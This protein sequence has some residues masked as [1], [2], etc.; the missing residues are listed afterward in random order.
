[1]LSDTHP[2]TIAFLGPL[3]LCAALA[4]AD[5]KESVVEVSD[6]RELLL[7][8]HLFDRIESLSFRLHSPS[9]REKVLDFD[10]PWEGRPSFGI[11]VC[12]YPVVFQDGDKFRMY[13]TSYYGLRLK[14]A[15]PARQFTCYCESDDGIHWRRVDLG[16][17]EF[18][19]GRANNI[20]RRGPECHN[21]APFIDTRPGVPE[22]ERYK[23]IGG[24]GKAYAFASAD[25]I[26]WRKLNEEP[27]LDGEEEAFDR[28]GAIRWGNNPGK[29]RAILDSLNVAF[30]DPASERYVLYFRAYLPCLS[31]DGKRNLPET[32]SVMRCVSKDFVNWEQIEPIDYGEPRREW[33]HSLYTTA[34]QP[35]SRSPHV[36]LGMPLRTSPRRPFHG[37]SFGL[38]ESAFMYSRDAKRFA[39]V[40]EPFLRPGRDQKNWSKHGNMMAWGMLRT[41]PDEL[42]VYYLQHDHQDDSFL[43]RGVLRVDGFRSLHAA[44]FPGGTAISKPIVFHGDRLEINAATGAGGGIRIGFLDA[45]TLE[46]LPDFGE[47]NES[48][49]P[50][51]PTPNSSKL[52][53]ASSRPATRG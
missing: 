11:S 17:V 18:A 25:G 6:R 39:L 52:R 38:S 41:A 23:A 47:S 45:K 33:I 19:G 46:P 50:A 27:I 36:Y 43:R 20:M 31:R 1:M 5:E 29:E 22:S 9:P 42:S 49:S 28:Y 53:S 14:P 30:W 2:V 21:F 15:D 24:N 16:R 12:G 34:L 37:T 7:D 35:Y 48:S 44:G 4:G 40:D 26:S 3:I 8:G 10:A 32:R 51:E 13:Y